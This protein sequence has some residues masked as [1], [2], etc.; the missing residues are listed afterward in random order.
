MSSKVVVKDRQTW[1][2]LLGKRQARRSQKMQFH[3]FFLQLSCAYGA[4]SPSFAGAL[5]DGESAKAL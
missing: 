5:L 4:L 3:S 2:M 1:R